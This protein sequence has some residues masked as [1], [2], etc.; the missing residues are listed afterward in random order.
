MT[1]KKGSMSHPGKRVLVA[2]ERSGVVRRAFRDEG[3]DAWSCD[4][5][6]AADGS[7]YHIQGDVLPL[8]QDHWDL[9]IAH[10]PCRYLC[11]FGLYWNKM[12]PERA[13]LKEAAVEFFMEFTKLTCRY[14]IENSVGCMS[15]LWR[16]PDQI[17]QP[18]QFGHDASK[19]TC[20]WLKGLPKLQPTKLVAPTIVNGKKRWA[21]QTPNGNNKLGPSKDR[22]YLRAITYDGVARAMAKQWGAVLGASISA[23]NATSKAAS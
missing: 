15:T 14:A 5:E 6:P 16:K 2:C 17:I 12:R 23:G 10:P 3:F 11:C 4:I 13:A 1:A 22:S 9:V 19:R 7:P 20:F 18:Y 8:L 21:N